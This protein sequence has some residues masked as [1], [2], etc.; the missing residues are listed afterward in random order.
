M[1]RKWLP[2]GALI[3]DFYVMLR[4]FYYFISCM[5]GLLLVVMFGVTAKFRQTYSGFSCGVHQ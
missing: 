4:A 3:S 2:K 1:Y 5:T